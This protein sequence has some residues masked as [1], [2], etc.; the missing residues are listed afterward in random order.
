MSL[1]KYDIDHEYR[2]SIQNKSSSIT[3]LSFN[4]SPGNEQLQLFRNIYR[5]QDENN[6]ERLEQ[7]KELLVCF[8]DLIKKKRRR[9]RKK[10]KEKRR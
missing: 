5:K 7:T 9:R 6:R 1:V 8:D 4:E 2:E 10:F 3:I